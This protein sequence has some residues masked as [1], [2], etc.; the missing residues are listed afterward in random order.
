MALTNELQHLLLNSKIE[1]AVILE[2]PGCGCGRSVLCA[3][4]VNMCRQQVA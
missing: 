2:G 1:E 3:C 4:G